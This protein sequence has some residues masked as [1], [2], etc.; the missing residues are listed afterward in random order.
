ME[1]KGTSVKITSDFVK[2]KFPNDYKKW[3]QAL[4]PDQ[5]KIFN[6][7]VFVG[8]WYPLMDSVII[9]TQVIAKM[10]Y[11]NNVKKAA[12]EMG[13]YSAKVALTGI[14]RVFLYVASTKYILQ[15]AKN[16]WSVYYRPAE[17][18]VIEST[19]NKAIFEITGFRKEETL[20][21]DRLGG[22]LEGVLELAKQ[23]S[24]GINIELTDDRNFVK[25]L[26]SAEWE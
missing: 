22:W 15:R 18:Q 1:I 4:G 5:Q 13:V 25:A 11:F 6:G 3:L 21:F 12:R 19:S 24:K 8:D 7:V 14:Y 23:K 10:F 17:F 20:I 9:P 2:D 16:V 26:V